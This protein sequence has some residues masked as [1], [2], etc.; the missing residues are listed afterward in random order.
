MLAIIDPGH[1]AL[2]RG[3]A[4]HA[5]DIHAFHAVRLEIQHADHLVPESRVADA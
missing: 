2:E 4:D 5:L 1:E 3:E